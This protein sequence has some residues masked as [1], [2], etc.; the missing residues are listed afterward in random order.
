MLLT[1]YW[2]MS[3]VGTLFAV[4]GRTL[5]GNVREI[6]MLNWLF[7]DVAIVGVFVVQWLC[8]AFLFGIFVIVVVGVL[9][10]NRKD[11]NL[12]GFKCDSGYHNNQQYQMVKPHRRHQKSHKVTIIYTY[13]LKDV[14]VRF[15]ADL[16]VVHRRSFISLLLSF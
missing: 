3:C 6:G 4:R 16:K 8:V 5:N 12:S 9:F 7:I 13:T 2:Q 15:E 11:F 14:C 10:N 1:E